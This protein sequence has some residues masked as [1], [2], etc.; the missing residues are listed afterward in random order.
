VRRFPSNG[1]IKKEYSLRNRYFTAISSSIARELLQIDTEFLPITTSTADDLSG[2]PT[3]MTLNPE[4]RAFSDF[5]C[6]FGTK[7]TEE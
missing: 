1:G 3:S 6:D 4:N 5:F 7:F 2:V